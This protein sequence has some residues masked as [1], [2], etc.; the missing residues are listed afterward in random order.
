M[1][2]VVPSIYLSALSD[3]LLADSKLLAGTFNTLHSTIY[4]HQYWLLDA[5]EPSSIHQ[6]TTKN[7][8]V[9]V[10]LLRNNELHIFEPKPGS[11]EVG[12]SI[13]LGS[14]T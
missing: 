3:K 10:L 9:G 12:G 2:V 14:T 7:E 5:S 8:G 4:A 1:A 6:F 13:P 11:H